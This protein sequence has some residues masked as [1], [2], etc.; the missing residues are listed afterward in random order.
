MA[1]KLAG[2]KDVKLLNEPTALAIAFMN[3][4]KEFKNKG[5]IILVFKFGGETLDISIAYANTISINYQVIAT[6]RDTKLGGDVFSNKLAELITLK[7][8]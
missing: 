2:M 1:A 6:K 5:G 7:L 8:K 3:N 4:N